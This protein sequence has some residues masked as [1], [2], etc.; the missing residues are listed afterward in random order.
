MRIPQTPDSH[1]RYAQA[2]LPSLHFMQI[3]GR[4]PVQSLTELHCCAVLHD[5][6]RHPP[7]MHVNVQPPGYGHGGHS[8]QSA[9]L[10]QASAALTELDGGSA[11]SH[12]SVRNVIEMTS[13]RC[14]D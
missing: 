14:M 2:V 4:A 6:K 1:T 5:S 9:A 13:E 8:V 11:F 7:F 3:I 10:V 12:A